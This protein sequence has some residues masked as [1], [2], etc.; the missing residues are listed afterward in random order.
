VGAAHG[1]GE[2]PEAH[3]PEDG[4]ATIQNQVESRREEGKVI[5]DD[6]D[7]EGRDSRE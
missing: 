6:R 3:H 2:H 5:Q 7:E 4:Y 1:P